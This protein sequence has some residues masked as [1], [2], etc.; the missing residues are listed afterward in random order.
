MQQALCY[1]GV[2]KGL[3]KSGVVSEVQIQKHKGSVMH[4]SGIWIKT[5]ALDLI[6]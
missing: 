3:F 2:E 5:A 1:L 4:S 6:S